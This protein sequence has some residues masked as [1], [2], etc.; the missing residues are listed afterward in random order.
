[1][2]N[3]TPGPWRVRETDPNAFGFC[4]VEAEHQ[5]RLLFVCNQT[6]E[7]ATDADIML[8]NSRLIAAAPELLEALEWLS[9]YVS[10]CED[11]HD[12]TGD[13]L[14]RLQLKASAAIKKAKGNA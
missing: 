5:N 4:R 12:A 13:Q 7:N 14:H 11:P 6:R 3:H 10:D 1:M 2:A 9:S 8:A